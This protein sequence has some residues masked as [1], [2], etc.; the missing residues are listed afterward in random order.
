[1]IKYKR[2]EKYKETQTETALRR[3]SSYGPIDNE[4]YY[5]VP[6]EAIIEKAYHQLLGDNPG[7]GDHYFTV[8]VPRQT[9]KTWVMQQILH[10]LR[11]DPRF[12]VLKINLEILKD[13]KNP[14]DIFEIIAAD[15]G[16][17][18]GKTF[19]GIDNQDKFQDIFKKDVLQ[20]PLILILDEFDAMIEEGITAVVSAFRNIY[21]Q[22]IDEVDLPTEQKSYLLHGVSL[23]GVRSVLGIENE[24]GSPFNVQRSLKIPNLTYEEV[25]EMF[26][27]YE[28]DSGQAVEEDVIRQLFFETNGQPGLIGWFG[29][30]LT[31]TY[32]KDKTKP[33]STRNFEIAYSAA[34]NVLPNNN[35]LNIISKA[36]KE[37]YIETVLEL[38]KTDQ[39]IPFTYRN[40]RLNYLYM[41][42]VID[43]EEVNESEYYVKFSSPFVQRCLF[44]YFSITIF[45]QMGRLFD[46]FTNLDDTITDTD[47]NIRN[48]GKRY[49]TYLAENRDWLLEDVP[50]RKDLRVYEA[51]YH[52]NFYSYVNQFLKPRG[53][54]V[55]PE[56]PTGNGKIDLLITYAGRHYGIEIKSYSSERDYNE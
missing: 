54:R 50:K 52:F 45:Q 11:K 46:P 26:K 8:W 27:W 28:K 41:N 37:P 43:K 49:E 4:Q 16:D 40:P 25:E 32:N 10:K 24:T 2:N 36:K 6:R 15:I 9:G 21:I 38:F 18:L 5:Y 14:A 22:R 17:G 23:I 1:M 34:L 48:L 44:D 20:K 31:E 7:K 55:V 47:I 35:V 3:F 42:G 39:K 51:V 13:R 30:L 33:I 29:E 19:T 12:D 56:F 53:G